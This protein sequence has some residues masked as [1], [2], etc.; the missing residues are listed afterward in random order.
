MKPDWLY[1]K[2][3]E[4]AFILLPPF[5]AVAVAAL[6]HVV[7]DFDNEVTLTGWIILVLCID[8]GHVYSTLFRTYF[9]PQMWKTRKELLIL[10]PIFV[11]VTGVLLFN[12]SA[13]WFWRMVAYLAVYHF[14]R[15]Q[16]GFF[17]IYARNE[18]V[19][20]PERV[21]N[22]LAIYSATVIPILIWHF[23]DDRIFYWMVKDDF[24]LQPNRYAEAACLAVLAVIQITYLVKE[25]VRSAKQKRFN[26]PKN[27]VWAGTLVS[28]FLGIVYFNGDF[29]FTVTN[30]VAH[31]I[32]YMA[33]VWISGK[34]SYVPGESGNFLKRVYTIQGIF[35]FIGIILL[36]AFMEEGFWNTLVW[37]E[38][39]KAQLFPGLNHLPKFTARE[40]LSLVAPLLAVPQLTH[41]VLDGFIWRIRKNEV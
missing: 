3:A 28:W 31:G 16:Y 13:L 17:R 38:T 18:T 19:S 36:F 30:V 25:I 32:P 33:L 23:R 5:L 4:S 15:Q 12:F 29:T 9:N 8:V 35:L 14:I 37:G 40:T 41:Y 22:T 1:N 26:I 11:W 20:K 10:I 39:D 2:Y 27:A 24:L 6:F 21:I 34:K 7:P